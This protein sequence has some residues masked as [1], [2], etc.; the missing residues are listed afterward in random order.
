MGL[1][2]WILTKSLK[3]IIAERD[4][5]NCT[6]DERDIFMCS[7]REREAILTTHP[8]IEYNQ[9]K[10]LA[11]SHLIWKALENSF[12]GDEHSKKLRLQSWIC[13]FQDAK[14][15]EDEYVRTYIGRI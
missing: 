6:K 8:K 1:G 4:L 12:K 11:T 7:M 14:M 5:E 13:A 2:Y 15:M 3:T 9:V 10:S